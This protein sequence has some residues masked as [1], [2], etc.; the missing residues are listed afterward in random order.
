MRAWWRPRPPSSSGACASSTVTARTRRGPWRS[1]TDWPRNG[2][3][4]EL[5]VVTDRPLPA[6][7]AQA[8][9][10]HGV[11]VHVELHGDAISQYLHAV[12]ARPSCDLVMIPR[13]LFGAT[14]D[15]AIEAALN[16]VSR[17]VLLVSA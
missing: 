15:A 11:R 7:L 14:P 6:A 3:T 4:R 17:P 13:S 8:L 16:R 5:F 1:S 10:A 2:H 12:L 9:K